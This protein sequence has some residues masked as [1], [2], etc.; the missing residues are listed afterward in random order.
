MSYAN[1][2]LIPYLLETQTDRSY[3]WWTILLWTLY[4]TFR[5]TKFVQ[6]KDV[7]AINI[8]MGE[9]ILWWQNILEARSQP[10]PGSD[11]GSCETENVRINEN[12]ATSE[13]TETRPVI[14]HI[15]DK[16]ELSE[17]E[18]KT[19]LIKDNTKIQ[20]RFCFEVEGKIK[21]MECVTKS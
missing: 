10:Y 3:S 8:A 19:S 18:R 11:E 9:Q 5:K 7:T 17:R 1:F 14:F 13:L 21:W 2:D 12:N 4:L 16:C 20:Y 15:E 6:D